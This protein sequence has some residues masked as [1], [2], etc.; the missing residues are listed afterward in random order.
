MNEDNVIYKEYNNFTHNND[1]EKIKAICFLIFDEEL[2]KINKLPDFLDKL[3][4]F[5]S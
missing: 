3:P 4:I 5:F 1:F 2:S